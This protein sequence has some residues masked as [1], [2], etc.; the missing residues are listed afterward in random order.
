VTGSKLAYH[1]LN[2]PDQTALFL[3]RRSPFAW[4]KQVKE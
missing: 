4:R 1:H 2:Q 3:E